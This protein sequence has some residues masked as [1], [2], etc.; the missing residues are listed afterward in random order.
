[1]CC[2][3]YTVVMAYLLYMYSTTT[4]CVKQNV[5]FILYYSDT[6]TKCC[7]RSERV[8]SVLLYYYV[9]NFFTVIVM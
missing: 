6:L 8:Q 2:L 1:M 5:L 7:K 4:V 3:P 9:H